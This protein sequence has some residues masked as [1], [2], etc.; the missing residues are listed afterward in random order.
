MEDTKKDVACG[1]WWCIALTDGEQFCVVHQNQ[2]LR[3][4]TPRPVTRELEQRYNETVDAHH[5]R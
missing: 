2:M 1:V 4:R 5:R 3:F